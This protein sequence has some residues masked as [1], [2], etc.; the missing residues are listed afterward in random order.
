MKERKPKAGASKRRAGGR[1]ETW[2]S[3]ARLESVPFPTPDQPDE[4]KSMTSVQRAV[5]TVT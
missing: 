5:Y 3:K 4:L 1:G 2:N